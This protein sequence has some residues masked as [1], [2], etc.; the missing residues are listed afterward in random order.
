M[1]RR[2][3]RTVTTHCKWAAGKRFLLRTYVASEKEHPDVPSR[4]GLQ[5]IGWDPASRQIRSWTFDSTG[6][7]GQGL[8]TRADGG[9]T[10]ESEGVLADGSPTTSTELI[11][12][13]SDNIIGWQ[14]I[15][16]TVGGQP[17]PD[18]E[19]VVLERVP[20]KP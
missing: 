5:I 11:E 4:T 14:S 3:D 8:W 15:N 18:T 16:R 12:R 2:D 19:Q 17:L 6:G 13:V 9:W 1:A 20:A 7:H 10:I